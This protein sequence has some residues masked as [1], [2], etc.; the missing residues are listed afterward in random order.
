MPS[1][2]PRV[3]SPL[4]SKAISPFVVAATMLRR[5]GGRLIVE[6]AKPT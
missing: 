4:L 3:V 1:S 6:S 2:S 5:G